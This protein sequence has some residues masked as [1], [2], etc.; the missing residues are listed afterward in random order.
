MANVTATQDMFTRQHA[1]ASVPENMAGKHAPWEHIRSHD[2]CVE[3]APECTRTATAKM[4]AP[5]IKHRISGHTDIANA[6][7]AEKFSDGP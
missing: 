2:M 4:Q 6:E 7:H 3:R 5:E 1:D